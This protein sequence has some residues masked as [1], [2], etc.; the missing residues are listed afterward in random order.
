VT[1][2][3]NFKDGEETFAARNTNGTGP[4]KLKSRE[5]DVRTVYVENQDWWNKANKKGNVTEIIY[6]PIMLAPVEY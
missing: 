1:A 4:Y 2:P 5:V 3:Q 6:T